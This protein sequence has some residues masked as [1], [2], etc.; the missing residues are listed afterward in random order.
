MGPTITLFIKKI[1]K[2][3]PTVLFTHLKIIL[4]QCFQFSVFSFNNNKFN[5]NGPIVWI[6]IQLKSN[7]V[8]VNV[9]SSG[10]HALFIGPA[11]T[12]FGKINFK[13]VSH[14]TIHVFKNYFVTVFSVFSNK[15]YPNKPI[16]SRIKYVDLMY[17]IKHKNVMYYKFV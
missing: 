9:L 17:I 2:M 6:W 3:G 11:S 13:T 14:G 4:L 1:L 8:C 5:P 15:Q 12:K 10:S 7:H 16:I